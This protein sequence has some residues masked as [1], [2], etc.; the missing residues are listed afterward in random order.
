L[1]V[2][3]VEIPSHR[4]KFNPG[5]RF[6]SPVGTIKR[7]LHIHQTCR[8]VDRPGS[9]RVSIQK[10]LLSLGQSARGSRFEEGKGL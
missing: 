5:Q 6:Q 8:R 1:V 4:P 7:A 2:G 9:I 3:T 10:C